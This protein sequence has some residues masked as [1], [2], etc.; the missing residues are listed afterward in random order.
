M[1]NLPAK[2]IALITA[3]SRGTGAVY[4]DRLPKRG[5]DLIL[6]A[7]SQAAQGAFGAP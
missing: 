6:V 4:A 2:G 5:Y 3:A 1:S 7:R